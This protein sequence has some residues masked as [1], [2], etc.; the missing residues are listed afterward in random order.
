[1]SSATQS[2]IG[3]IASMEGESRNSRSMFLTSQGSGSELHCMRSVSMSWLEVAHTLSLFQLP[4]C[5]IP[6]ILS[7]SIFSWS[8]TP[9]TQAGIIPRSSPH[10]SIPLAESSSGSFFSALRRQ[11]SSWRW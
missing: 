7:E 2:W 10:A 6:R 9:S 11:K 3:K 5:C 1:M 4:S 8:I